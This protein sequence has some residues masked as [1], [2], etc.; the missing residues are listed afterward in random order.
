MDVKELQ[1]LIKSQ[2]LSGFYILAGEEDYLKKHY[3]KE[4]KNALLTDEGLDV[5]N[6]TAFDGG[7]MDFAALREA[8]YAPPMM[9]ECKLVEWKYANLDAIKPAE[10]KF[11][12]D[13]AEEKDSFPYSVFVIMA[14]ADGF[15]SGKS[16]PTKLYKTLSQYFNIITLDK[17]SDSQ[18]A[19]W[20]KRHFDAEGIT[21]DMPCVNA[22]L[23]K[24]GH[25]MQM[26]SNE[27]KKLCAYLKQNG[28]TGLEVRDVDEVC[29]SNPETSAF[30][31]SDAVINKNAKGAFVALDELKSRRTDAAV[32]IGM[33]K[34]AYCDLVS[35]SLLIDEGKDADTISALLKSHP[36]KT[37]L[38]IS[39]AKKV[40]TKRLAESLE[41][42]QRI[43]KASKSGGVSGYTAIEIFI[44]QNV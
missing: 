39:S 35:V 24:V 9:S 2:N 42:L 41:R 3:L 10:L 13:L 44:T 36:Y 25:S 37:K 40:G 5:F 1:G 18:L 22:L 15:E 43:D 6:H 32:V 33:L 21:V 30:A 34:K 16:K 29:C 19:S 17:S 7:N 27:I 26:L 28:R 12:C 20:I 23:F 31:L 14:S 4:I 11:L 38:Y 8:L